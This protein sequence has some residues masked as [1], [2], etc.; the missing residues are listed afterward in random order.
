[1]AR[2]NK[3][4][5]LRVLQ[6]L[7]DGQWGDLIAR[8]ERCSKEERDAFNA[9]VRAYRLNDPRPYRVI[10]RRQLINEPFHA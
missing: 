7:Y 4:Q 6:G 8:D 10:S 1:M 9:D 5:Y 3:Y 2:K